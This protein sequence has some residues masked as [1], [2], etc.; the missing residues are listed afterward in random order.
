MAKWSDLQAQPKR[1]RD[2][3]VLAARFT[4]ASAPR[5]NAGGGY[6]AHQPFDSRLRSIKS[7]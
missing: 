5:S 1:L 6:P 2:A 3:A 4:A 7:K